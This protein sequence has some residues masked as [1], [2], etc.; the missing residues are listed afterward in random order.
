MLAKFQK[1]VKWKIREGLAQKN[2]SLNSI[3][4]SE[5]L[6]GFAMIVSHC[7]CPCYS[8]KYIISFDKE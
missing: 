6:H 8:I 5:R 1:W 4:F 3:T 2:Q 7:F